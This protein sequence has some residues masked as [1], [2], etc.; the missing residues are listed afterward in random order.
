MDTQLSNMIA[1]GE[2]VERPGGIVKEL[3]ENAIDAHATRIEIHCLEGGI[4]RIE[5]IDN[6]DGMD[7]EDAQRAFARHATSK[8]KTTDDLWSIS[9]LGFRGEAL[10][11]I[12][13]VSKTTLLTSDG[14]ESTSV[15][16][17]YGEMVEVSDAPSSKGTTLIVEGLFQ[18]TPARLK[19]LKSS[20]YEAAVIQDH[21]QR[22]ALSHPE[23]AFHLV[24][25]G[26]ESLKTSGMGSLREVMVQIYG[27]D[28]LK[29]TF[30]VKGSDFDYQISGMAS[31]PHLTRANKNYIHLFI[32][33]RMIK[34]YR[35]TKA[36]LEGYRSYLFNERYPIVV[37]NIAMDERLV[38]VNVHPSKW[39]IRLSKQQQLEYLI[40]D[41]VRDCLK[42]Q[43][44]SAQVTKV[45]SFE[46]VKKIEAE[47]NKTPQVNLDKIFVKPFKKETQ[48]PVQPVEVFSTS[49][50]IYAQ[51][52]LDL[53]ET[54]PEI[55]VLKVHEQEEL[56]KPNVKPFPAMEA[57]GQLHGRYVL[58]ESEEGL[59]IIDQH[60]AQ[61]RVNYERIRRQ[62]D[63]QK[64]AMIDM[65]VPVMVQA[66]ANVM[67]RMDELND[68]LKMFPLHLEAF[69]QTT[70]IARSIPLWM[71]KVDETAFL[72]D[73]IDLFD[74]EKSLNP[75]DLNKDRIA[76]MACHHSI[77]FNR[78][79]SHAEMQ[80]V[81]DALKK[82][83][84]PYHCPHGRPTFILISQNQ[85][86]KDFKR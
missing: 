79:L 49:E 39:E 84:Q 14:V 42:A 43:F 17:E 59:Y 20:H 21:V 74:S 35:L 63:E 73:L 68:L 24:I 18:R 33:G 82:C 12:A 78:V 81:I 66:S 34:S 56:Y 5:I 60:A 69:G 67:H 57:I 13:S 31:L 54:V 83:D 80:E 28:C 55:D 37:L 23:I 7:R 41:V 71:Q 27:R 58:A 19:H 72:Q 29:N 64:P 6:G 4:A 53:N 2:V 9:T 30:E 25:D 11:S 3:I 15:K 50:K 22:F 32:N 45:Q 1:A 38:D 77:R 85:L 8:I 26:K 86:I 46:P 61:E 47:E 36:V 52:T 40:Q 16:V 62:F 51:S 44:A 76:T 48:T 10:P 75:T 70:L 65:L